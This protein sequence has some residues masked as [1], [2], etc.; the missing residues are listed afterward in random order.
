MGL[1]FES[2]PGE[3]LQEIFSYLWAH[4]ILHSFYRLNEYLDRILH[5]YDQYIIRLCPISKNQFNLICQVIQPTQIT[6]IVIEDED[7]TPNQ[8][9]L[10]FSHFPI[11]SFS[12]LRSFTLL[13]SDQYFCREKFVPTFRRDRI[14]SIALPYDRPHRYSTDPILEPYI[15]SLRRLS[16]GRPVI[17]KQLNQLRHLAITHCYVHRFKD[18]LIKVPNLRSLNVKLTLD[19]FPWWSKQMPKMNQLRRFFLQIACNENSVEFEF[20]R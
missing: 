18:L 8:L 12:N 13:S 20:I 4:D 14:R 1:L 3:L 17:E 6:S 9:D 2:L 16:T 10:F 19:N 11:G 15:H 5:N 7:G